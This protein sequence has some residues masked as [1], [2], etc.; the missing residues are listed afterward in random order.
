MEIFD[1]AG[2]KN[3]VE[4]LKSPEETV[5]R[6]NENFKN[7]Q[8]DEH[9][10]YIKLPENTGWNAGSGFSMTIRFFRSLCL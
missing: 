4:N 8:N 6:D 7:I 2:P 3:N 5:P 1:G 9:I 10:K